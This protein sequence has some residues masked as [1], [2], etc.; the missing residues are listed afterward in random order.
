M[1]TNELK[2]EKWL[3]ITST[4]N[5]AISDLGRVRNTNTNYILTPSSNGQRENDY[6]FLILDGKKRYISHLVL[7]AFVG[8]KPVGYE[9]DHKNRQ[10]QDN[11]LVNLRYLIRAENRSHKGEKHGMAKLSVKLVKA[12]KSLVDRGFLQKDVA[13]IYEVSASTISS[14][15]TG[16]TWNHV[17]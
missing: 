3:P 5:Y 7:E 6:L 1:T 17:V 14:V 9:C 12:I 15:I 8:E 4:T 11:R 13:E 2:N 10:K 16:R